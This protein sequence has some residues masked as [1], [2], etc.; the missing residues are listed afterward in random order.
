MGANAEI[1]YWNTNVPESQRTQ[2]CPE[3]LRGLSPKDLGVLSTQDADYHLLT[4][5]EVRVIAAQNRLDHFQ[6]IPSELR[7]YKAFTFKLAQEYGSVTNFILTRRLDWTFSI[8]PKSEPFECPDDFKILYNDWPYGIDEKIVH[9]VV[10]TKFNLEDDESTGELT[11]TARHQIEKF[12][13]ETFFTHVDPDQ[14]SSYYP[15]LVYREILLAWIL[16]N[17][18]SSFG[19][20]T[21]HISSLSTQWSTS[22]S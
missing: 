2:I 5:E 9:L 16:T 19:S 8:Q 11:P 10:W 4:W 13:S 6:R 1:A 22:I 21:G 15:L 17:L 7:R 18:L 3:F 20:G 12:V 14:V